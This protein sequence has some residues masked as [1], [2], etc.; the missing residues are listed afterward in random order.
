MNNLFFLQI[1]RSFSEGVLI[2]TSFK[3]LNLKGDKRKDEKKI[4]K[5]TFFYFLLS[6]HAVAT[7]MLKGISPNFSAAFV[8]V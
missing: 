1:I 6:Y 3:V 4:E 8:R 7:Q 5:V 2:R